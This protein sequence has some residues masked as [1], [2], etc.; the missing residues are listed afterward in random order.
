MTTAQQTQTRQTQRAAKTLDSYRQ[1]KL[2]R[3][4]KRQVRHN[5]TEGR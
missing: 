4:A 3:R 1:A 2:A 5:K